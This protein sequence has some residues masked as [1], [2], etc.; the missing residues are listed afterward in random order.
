MI[1]IN[2]SIL[3]AHSTCVESLHEFVN[4]LGKGNQNFEIEF[5]NAVDY[6]QNLPLDRETKLSWIVFVRNLK[7]STLFYLMQ[8]AA[9][10]NEKYHVM[11]PLTGQYEEAASIEDARTLQ[12]KIKNDFLS[13]NASL[14]TIGQEVFI[15]EENKTLWQ[16]VE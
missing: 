2:K 11:N 14:F 8:G 3:E 6:I 1:I 12:Q 13:A 9:V 7:E 4:V 10:V 16:V 15:A 5:E